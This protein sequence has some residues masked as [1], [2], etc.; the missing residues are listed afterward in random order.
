[1]PPIGTRVRRGPDWDPRF[2]EQDSHGPGTVVSHGR[3][4]ILFWYFSFS[5]LGIFRVWTSFSPIISNKLFC[6][7]YERLLVMNCFYVYESWYNVDACELCICFYLCCIKIYRFN[8][9]KHKLFQIQK[10]VK[11]YQLS[12]NRCQV[13]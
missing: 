1:M 7:T 9:S 6:I 3:D 11:K 5:I 12:R 10:T 8:Y 4:G 2:R 13:S